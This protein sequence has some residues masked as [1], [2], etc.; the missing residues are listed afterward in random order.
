MASDNVQSIVQDSLGY[1]WMS[2]PGVGLSRFDGYQFKTFRYDADDPAR[3]ALDFDP[4]YLMTDAS[5]AVWVQDSKSALI[6]V[7][8]LAKYEAKTDR[9]IKYKIELKGTG[10]KRFRFDSDNSSVWVGTTNGIAK[11]A[12]QDGKVEN[13]VN[14]SA[15]D[16]KGWSNSDIA[17]FQNVV[18]DIKDFGSYLLVATEYGL[19][20]FDKSSGNFSRPIFNRAD[21]AFLH[22]S[23]FIVFSEPPGI[24]PN[25]LWVRTG[26]SWIKID[27]TISILERFDLPDSLGPQASD[28]GKGA[29]WFQG[30]P[31]DK[32]L[33]KYDLKTRTLATYRHNAKLDY[34]IISNTVTEVTVD[35]EM[36][37]WVCTPLGVSRLK[38]PELKSI[39]TSFE[40]PLTYS[41]VFQG[42]DAEVLLVA[43]GK[44]LRANVFPRSNLIVAQLPI[45]KFGPLKFDPWVNVE[46][47]N[48]QTIFK[49]KQF[50][51]VGARVMGF[52][53]LPLD[54][55]GFLK[56]STQ[57]NPELDPVLVLKPWQDEF[58]RAAGEHKLIKLEN[59]LFGKESILHYSATDDSNT[60]IRS[61]IS[62][63]WED[64][65][66]D[67][68]LG[69]AGGGLNRV[70]I[71]RAYGRSGSV[72]KFL[73]DDSDAASISSNVVY[74]IYPE[75]ENSFWVLTSEGVDLAKFD[76]ES[77]RVN[78]QHAFSHGG[79]PSF[80]FRGND[81]KLVLGTSGGLYFAD[82]IKGNYNFGKPLLKESISGGVVDE[83][84]LFW[85]CSPR[86]LI[87]FDS[88]NLHAILFTQG[89]GIDH[90]RR[91]IHRTAD[92]K[93]ILVDQFGISVVEP[94]SFQP[95]SSIFIPV[96]TKV[97]VNNL[98]PAI[99]E[100]NSDKFNLA[101]SVEVLKELT[102][103]YLHN[104]FS[105]EY[106][107]MEMTAPEKNLYRHKLE[108]YDPDWIETDYKDR[109]ASY[110]NLDPD[111]YTLRVR[112]SNHH[113]VW[114]ENERTLRVIILPPPWRTW[115][116]YTGY[117]L[118]AVGLLLLGRRNLV[119]R[120]RLKA[121]LKVAKLEQEKEHFELEKAKEVDRV[122]TSFF[123]NI[124]HEF[125]TPLTLIKGPVT[126]MLEQFKDDP[127]VQQRLKLVQRNSDLLLKLI[128]QLLDLAKLESGTLKVEK[129]DGE[130]Y[131]FIRGIA[132]S[133]ESLA[134]QKGIDLKVE[135]PE[136]SQAARFDK[137]KVE[138]VLINLIN[139]AIKFTSP[140]GEVKVSASIGGEVT[141]AEA[142]RRGGALRL[143]ISDTGIGI[144]PEHQSKIFERFHQ[145][146]ESHKEVG[147]GIGL[148][149]VKELVTLMEGEISVKSAQGEGSEFKVTLPLEL[150]SETEVSTP[151]FTGDQLSV[152]GGG[153]E[154]S[155]GSPTTDERPL[156]TD[157]RSPNTDD[158]RPQVLV[159]ED[160]ADLRAFIIDS[161]GTEF[162]FHEAEN[163]KQGLTIATEQIPDMIISDVMMP[164]MDG[165]EMTKHIK[166]DIR[167]SHIPL[168]LLT[169][170]SG[171]DS[172]LEG[173][174]KGADDY[175]TKPF[176]K[177]ELLLKVRN[178]TARM[179]K[180]REKMKSEVLSSAPT[181][182]VLSQDEQF[183]NK[184][185]ET[186]IERMS[187]EQLSVES[188]ADDLGM[189][190]VQLY[191]KVSALTGMAVNELIRKLRLQRAAQLLRQ[192]W[193]PV[194][195]VAYE[196]GFSNLSYFSKVFKDEFGALPSSYEKT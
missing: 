125:R 33:C 82:R 41:G 160:N 31:G 91:S 104:N 180:L 103:D 128:N 28:W 141:T 132:G 149:L 130:V 168:I 57:R 11:Y 94:K 115:W 120:E 12:L 8:H 179:Q 45:G 4:G 133:F 1:I 166:E 32:G 194:S 177:Q 155:N 127:K 137:D 67:V 182:K 62:A 86:G 38:K 52:L 93:L 3:S 196:V 173:L 124:S 68:W 109:T 50:L 122:K 147:T 74:G 36:N 2:H 44:N 185:K 43:E 51:W 121:N 193:G 18:N 75:G 26:N 157:H 25:Y 58:H 39:N 119:Q 99:S 116:A 148:A 110:T 188:L 107:S 17:R 186:I 154:G 55:D 71:K 140:G 195:Q 34:S 61:S 72:T 78:F 27:K 102:L 100:T 131:S 164:E 135:V 189:S 10:V 90:S 83:L 136:G 21:S 134:R 108:G 20:K 23:T 24:D 114:S 150:A 142:L 146:S 170:K 53:G 19:W 191:R 54:A 184:V 56:P 98:E 176:N 95:D 156:I 129:T 29:Y 16:A 92:G 37:V 5:G 105:I 123:T 106:S 126:E 59:R 171:E 40:F 192:N 145:V 89:D 97:W 42:R 76:S 49:G 159:V 70:I 162:K 79:T 7:R 178:G 46:I 175:L 80:L 77:G 66:G 139:N 172:K 143:T 174:S 30:S 152:I 64:P 6:S 60:L 69:Q 85:L 153:R 112:A 81:D 84:G 101:R 15:S 65:K 22:E 117:G 163:G 113:G 35:R 158:S 13:Y 88:K 190:R 144:P 96:L 9:F 183:L 118:L 14:T 151:L 111:T 169:A 73:H 181:E 187:D 48:V 138:T 63:I 161:L 167:T 87:R 165:M 47:P